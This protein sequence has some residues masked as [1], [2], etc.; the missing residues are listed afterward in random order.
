MKSSIRFFIYHILF[1]LFLIFLTEIIFGSWFDPDSFGTTIR[2]GRLKNQLYEVEHNGEKYVFRYK[3]NYYG[4]RG[5]EIDPEKIKIFFLGGSHGNEKYKPEELTIVGRLNEYLA[6]NREEK[7]KI[8]NASQDG[9][10]SFGFK[11]FFLNFYPKIKNFNPEKMILY[12]GLTD[13]SL[14]EDSIK[15]KLGEFNSKL[16]WDNLE[17][18]NKIKKAKDYFKNN[19]FFISKIKIIQLKYYNKRKLKIETA[20]S[21][22]SE[23][24]L[25]M[26]EN[27][28]YMNYFEAINKYSKI[29][30][31][32]KYSKCKKKFLNNLDDILALT[33]KN[34]I[35]IL[36]I[37]NINYKG[38]KDDWLF[39]I[40]LLTEEFA[41][42][43]SLPLIDVSKIPNITRDDFY[44]DSHTTPSGSE[45]IAQFIYP[46]VINFLSLTNE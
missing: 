35:K 30:M 11:K 5:E 22:N 3:K 33:K 8:Y 13:G 46:E 2:N 20:A 34:K 4:F 24:Y 31:E 27:I 15:K 1:V 19:S 6:N 40:N 7:I 38:V 26:Q 45:K 23:S 41:N 14:C 43:N 17:E 29:E 28:K 44:D 32:N 39:Y 36:L 37:N 9:Y 21:I 42:K 25:N 10:S 12:I 18:I 16:V